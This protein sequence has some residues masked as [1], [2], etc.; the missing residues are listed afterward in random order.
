MDE[1]IIGY[2]HEETFKVALW[3]SK[4]LG[5]KQNNG[6]FSVYISCEELLRHYTPFNLSKLAP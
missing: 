2:W 5:E 3:K 6:K 1:I 4:R